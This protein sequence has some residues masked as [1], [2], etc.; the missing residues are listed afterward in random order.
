MT[1]YAINC[2]WSIDAATF[3]NVVLAFGDYEI[4][5]EVLTG[6]TV[7]EYADLAE[8]DEEDSLVR[9]FYLALNPNLIEIEEN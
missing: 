6:L 1:D 9:S 7:D 4:A 5:A 2:S 3:K 8:V